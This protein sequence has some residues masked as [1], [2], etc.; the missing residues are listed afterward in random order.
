[1]SDMYGIFKILTSFSKI[2]IYNGH[3]HI[4]PIP[5]SPADIASLPH[6]FSSVGDMLLNDTC[7]V[8]FRFSHLFPG[9]H[10]QWPS[11]HHSY[12]TIPSR[13]SFIPS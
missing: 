12:S 5:Q 8:Y 6:S 10:L 2:F 4:I 11:S 1:M 13:Y 7:M 9:F 3:L